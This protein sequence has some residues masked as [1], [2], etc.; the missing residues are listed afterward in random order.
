MDLL[1]N[2]FVEHQKIIGS[3]STPEHN[4]TQ[5]KKKLQNANWRVTG[6]KVIDTDVKKWVAEGKLG[7]FRDET[8]DEYITRMIHSYKR[9]PDHHSPAYPKTSSKDY[10]WNFTPIMR[11]AMQELTEFLRDTQLILCKLNGQYFHDARGNPIEA[12]PTE[13]DEFTDLL[14]KWSDVEKEIRVRGFKRCIYSKGSAEG[15]CPEM[16]EYYNVVR[17]S[18]CEPMK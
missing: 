3:R 16:G 18:S 15:K 8:K 14:G 5:I 2:L 12:S 11:K 1:N 13:E 10:E 6:F 7:G 17:C 9:F 4:P